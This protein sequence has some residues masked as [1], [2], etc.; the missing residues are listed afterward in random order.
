MKATVYTG[1]ACSW[2]ERV[3][4]L[5]KDNDYEI[6]EI[7][8]NG[9]ILEDLQTKFNKVIRTVPQVIID[10]ILVGGYHEV[11]DLMKGTTSVNKI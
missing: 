5:L 2:C 11:E 10:D 8:V 3:K 6:E 9:A 1:L 4:A 7:Q